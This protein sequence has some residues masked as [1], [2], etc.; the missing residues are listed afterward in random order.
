MTEY[1]R[2]E[3]RTLIRPRSNKAAFS[4]LNKLSFLQNNP[5]NLDVCLIGLPDYP[6]IDITHPSDMTP[7]I[8]KAIKDHKGQVGG[9]VHI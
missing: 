6:T 4:L 3:L 2:M 9:Y 8:L 7:V 1:Y 5:Y